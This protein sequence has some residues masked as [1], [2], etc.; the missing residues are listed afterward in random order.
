M[1]IS[2]R[3]ALA[4]VAHVAQDMD[5]LVDQ[6][7]GHGPVALV[8]G[9]ALVIAIVMA[10]AVRIFRAFLFVCRPNE[11]LI[12]SGKRTVLPSGEALNFQVLQAGRHWQVPFVQSVKRMDVRLI[13]IELAVMKMFS[14]GGI[15]LDVHAIANVKITS[16]PLH[17]H[18]A[19][20]RFLGKPIED[21]RTTARQTL[22]GK[23][24]DVLAQLTPEQ[25]TE[26]RIE[27]ANQLLEST[28]ADFNRLGLHLDTLK[29]LRVEDEAKYLVNIGRTQIANAIR[30]AE[31]AEN[32][33]NQEVAQEEAAARQLAE[34]A[35]K[36]AEIGVAQK[37]NQ[38]RALVGQLEG[39][40]QSVEREAA[41]AAEQARAEAEQE[42]QEVRKQLETRR[43]HAEVVLPAEAKR[44][45]AELI[46]EGEAAPRRELGAA[47]ATVMQAMSEAL[48]AA[49][50][51]AREMFVL[52]QLDTLVAQV[53]ARVKTIQVGAVQ[54][55]DAGDGK[56]VPALAASYPATVAT[57]MRTL[58]ELTGVDVTEMLAER[59]P[60][61]EPARGGVR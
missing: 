45:A 2:G 33:A 15:P 48:T 58:G 28:T 60:G 20:E 61:R 44:A 6:A 21:I 59:D 43:L 51:Q 8:I 36:Q 16:D 42:L 14:H 56:A 23:L 50:A 30:D 3:F 47:N 1:I 11:M 10:I 17:V 9:G 24:R 18:N 49:G 5:R 26:D 52:S 22:E 29:V 41:V 54:V 34:V 53:A 38:L 4:T 32:Q 7:R 31:N 57:V 27:F 39:A 40:A 19:V 35:Q 13:P 37:R 55:V 46:A 12:V 25:V